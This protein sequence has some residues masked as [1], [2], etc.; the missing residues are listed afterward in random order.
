M[1][2][3]RGALLTFS[4]SL[5]FAETENQQSKTS[6]THRTTPNPSMPKRKLTDA[7]M[8]VAAMAPHPPGPGT[9]QSHVDVRITTAANAGTGDPLSIHC[10]PRPAKSSDDKTLFGLSWVRPPAL[11]GT[12]PSFP[13]PTNPPNS[14]ITNSPPRRRRQGARPRSRPFRTLSTR[15]VVFVTR[16][17]VDLWWP[18]FV[19]AG[20]ICKHALPLSVPWH[21]H[22]ARA[23]A[24]SRIFRV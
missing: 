24:P 1:R 4:P 23:G 7:S 21:A 16:V 13:R 11:S 17:D 10:S 6:T 9:R 19:A 12:M 3:E 18:L 14:P 5:Q 20:R 8:M 15:Q 22:F 2:K